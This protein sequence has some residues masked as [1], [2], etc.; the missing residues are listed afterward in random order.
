MI[1][2]LQND[3]ISSERLDAYKKEN[4]EFKS[5]VNIGASFRVVSDETTKDDL[6]VV[7]YDLLKAGV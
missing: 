6:S 2:F 1:M 7:F 5:V 3:D 4:P